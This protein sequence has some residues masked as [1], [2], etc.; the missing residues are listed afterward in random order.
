MTLRTVSRCSLSR[1]H[2]KSAGSVRWSSLLT[3]AGLAKVFQAGRVRRAGGCVDDS[4]ANTSV[5]FSSPCDRESRR[6]NIV[7][8]TAF[9]LST[10]AYLWWGIAPPIMRAWSVERSGQY[11][12][13]AWPTRPWSSGA[14]LCPWV[15]AR[16]LV[17]PLIDDGYF[18][19]NRWAASF[20]RHAETR[21]EAQ[22]FQ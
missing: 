17:L 9:G 6:G 7:D 1:N 22:E 12:F 3:E 5:R 19:A 20:R 13:V 18:A 10:Y 14:R 15:H 8:I 11:G 2:P 16:I 21:V 4:E